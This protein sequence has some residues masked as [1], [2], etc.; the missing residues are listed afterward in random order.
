MAATAFLWS[1]AGLFIKLIDWNPIAI[2]GARSFI[3]SLV[4]L[5]FLRRPRLTLSF[6]Q[7]AAGVANA[8]TMLLFVIANKTTT[9]ANA[10][11]LQYVSP[12][13]T[14]VLGM[15]ILKERVRAA[16]WAAFPLV[17]LGMIVMFMDKIGGGTALGNGIALLSGLTFSFYFIFMRMQKEGSPIESILLSHW[18]TAGICLV[19]SF[20][21]P[22]PVV[23]GQSL[24][25][26]LALGIFQI[27]ITA[28]LFAMAI[29]RVSAVSSSLISVIEPVFNPL[30]V[31][32]VLGETPS[33]AALVG[34]GI[35]ITAI[36]A[37]SVI[38]ARR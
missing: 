30:W 3:A 5:A 38:V 31:F 8:A 27:G 24:L 33:A 16:Q 17:A 4:I 29:K 26:M 34:G 2:A 36:T 32:I 9:A 25:A 28:V 12:L 21:L 10:I 11:L 19:V 23:T 37:V 1:T 35:I 6:P 22:V 7:I 14:A 20:F 18:I 13:F 15:F